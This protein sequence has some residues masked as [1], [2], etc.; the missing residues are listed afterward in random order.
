MS[1]YQWLYARQC[2]KININKLMY[3]LTLKDY[4]KEKKKYLLGYYST[5]KWW[6]LFSKYCIYH[7][8]FINHQH[9]LK[10]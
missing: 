4:Q 8:Y 3:S 10:G 7:A 2:S 5:Q 9:L 1:E 6:D